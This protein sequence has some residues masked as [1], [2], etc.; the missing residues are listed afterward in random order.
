MNKQTIHNT[1]PAGNLLEAGER[2]KSNLD[3]SSTIPR[4]YKVI[5]ILAGVLASVAICFVVA[6]AVGLLLTLKLH[7]QTS[8]YY[9]IEEH[10]GDPVEVNAEKSNQLSMNVRHCMNYYSMT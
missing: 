2:T 1:D 4:K 10:H 3:S 7:T 6:I 8:E 5:V 9:D